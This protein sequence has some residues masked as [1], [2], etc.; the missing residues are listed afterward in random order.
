LAFG[1]VDGDGWLD[2]AVADNNQLGG[3]GRFKLYHNDGG[4]LN[5]SPSWQSSTG[6]YGASVSWCDVDYD[7]DLDL[8]TGRWWSNVMIYENT[9]TT[10]TTTPTWQS[11]AGSIVVEEI[12][13]ADIDGDGVCEYVES[14][15]IVPGKKLYY[16]ARMPFHSVDSVIVDGVKLGY[17]Q[18]CYSLV[19]GWVSVGTAPLIY[20]YVYYKWSY[21]PDLG[22]SNWD[23]VNYLFRNNHTPDFLAGD[24]DGSGE[25]DID[26]IVFLVSFIFAS[27]PAPDPFKSGDA[28][29]SFHID[30]DDAVYLI[31]HVFL[32]GPAPCYP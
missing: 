8:A 32:L 6:G 20:M 11:A 25:I 24:A 19:D 29:C 16:L 18:Y 14:V 13:F 26:D 9:G 28:D 31:E 15:D 30:V 1:D 17:D 27:G 22:V 5:T 12:Q 2:L 23:G 7:G 21:K 10:L 3:T 4:T